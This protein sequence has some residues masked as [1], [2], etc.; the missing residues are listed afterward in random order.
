MRVSGFTITS[1][2]RNRSTSATA[3]PTPGYPGTS[4]VPSTPTTFS[5]AQPNTITATRTL[6]QGRRIAF[7]DPACFLTADGIL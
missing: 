2:V 4:N 5:Q 3:A 6:E 7:N 1:T